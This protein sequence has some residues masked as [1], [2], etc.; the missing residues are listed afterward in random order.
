MRYLPE[1]RKFGIRC[2]QVGVDFLTMG[3]VVRNGPISLF[4]RQRWKTLAGD[5]FRR[6]ALQKRQNDRVERYARIIDPVVR[7][8]AV[9]R[10]VFPLPRPSRDRLFR[11]SPCVTVL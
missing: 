2:L 1:C 6:Q 11:A 3:E 10:K 7:R 8:R 5:G 9:G 4:K